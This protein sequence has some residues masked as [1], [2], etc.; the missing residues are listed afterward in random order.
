[1]LVMYTDYIFVHRAQ[2]ITWRWPA[3]VRLEVETMSV[4]A[5]DGSDLM[6]M[7]LAVGVICLAVWAVSKLFPAKRDR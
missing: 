2:G 5:Y 1:M 4:Y 7:V 3:G 6:L